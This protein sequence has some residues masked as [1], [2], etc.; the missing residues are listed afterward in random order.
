MTTHTKDGLII[1][2]SDDMDNEKAQK[3]CACSCLQSPKLMDY[4]DPCTWTRYFAPWCASKCALAKWSGPRRL[5]PMVVSVGMI[6]R[7]S[8]S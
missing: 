6:A 4:V 1:G 2:K 8:P 5:C 7:V 3:P